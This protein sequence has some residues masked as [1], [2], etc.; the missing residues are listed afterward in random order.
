MG[1]TQTRIIYLGWSLNWT[2][3]LRKSTH[4]VFSPVLHSANLHAALTVHMTCE[5]CM[6]CVSMRDIVCINVECLGYKL[7]GSAYSCC[8][9][10]C[11][12]FVVFFFTELF[13]LFFFCITLWYM[14][15]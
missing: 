10:L 6:E 4:N 12:C 9:L 14:C 11:V 15:F 3:L 8:F 2:S 1:L 5:I 7:C 13:V